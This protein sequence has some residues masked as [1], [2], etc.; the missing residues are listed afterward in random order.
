M[1][2]MNYWTL[3]EQ[4]GWLP[5]KGQLEVLKRNERHRVIPAGR[6]FGKSFV[7]G[8]ELVAEAFYTRPLADQLLEEGKRREFW[9]VG[10][11]YSDSEKEFRVMWN[12]L[13][14]LGVPF[15]KPGSYN[16]PESG[17]LHLKL[18]DGAFQVHGKSA[19]YPDTLVGE[20]LSGVI[21]A[22]AAKIK[23]NVWVKHIRPTLSD[24]GGWSIHSSTPEGK[25]HFYDKYMQGQDESNPDWW[26]KRM[27]AWRNNYV[28][29]K[30]TLDNHVDILLELEKRHPNR[31]VFDLVKE[32]NLIID[33][34]VLD[35][36]ND[37]TVEAFKQEIGADFTE[38]VG[39][40][41]KGFDEEV[42]VGRLEYNPG[43]ETWGATDY[44]FTNPNV[45]LLI[46][47]GPWGEINVLD[48]IYQ[49]G[50]TP[51]EFAEEIVQ[52]GMNPTGLLGFYPDPEDPGASRVLQNRLRVKA[53]GGTGGE[54]KYRL[55]AI[56]YALKTPRV[57]TEE[58]PIPGGASKWRPQLMFDYRCKNT[59]SDMLEYRY[60][61]K[62]DE[63]S[64]PGQEKPMKKNDHGCEAL[65]RFM[66]GRF[67]SPQDLAS[68]TRVAHGSFRRRTT[69]R[70]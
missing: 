58:G 27:P 47:V 68:A 13:K 70:R 37:L 17:E 30:P 16:N 36:A 34:E 44:G 10:P 43:W 56:R 11:E 31:S 46:Q 60:P 53:K 25:N 51:E 20:G 38:F 18:W 22:E 14:R 7:G 50:L 63:N 33:P 9:I 28:Y 49:E 24:F 32:W 3:V 41:F 69:M 57:D 26:S 54:L 4:L 40:V 2:A 62:K 66:R 29:K 5:H 35:L 65:G 8:H 6:R 52:R 1:V 39:R 55:D 67:G 61:D 23:E 15:D 64:T 45:W 21:M 12:V 42:H 48:E 19:K 59:I